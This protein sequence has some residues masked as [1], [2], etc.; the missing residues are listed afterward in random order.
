[1]ERLKK[2]LYLIL[3]N[4]LLFGLCACQNAPDHSVVTSKNDGSFDS[5]VV[6]SAA[7]SKHGDIL[8]Q[9]SETFYS[10]D[11]TVEFT[12]NLHET[13]AN[14]AMPVVEV[15]PHYLTSEEAQRVAS[16]LFGNVDFYE[17]EP[18][19]GA[20]EDVL[21]KQDCKEAIQ[22]WSPYTNQENLV[23]LVGQLQGNQELINSY[24]EMIQNEIAKYTMLL[25][26]IPSERTHMKAKWEFQPDWYY[27]YPEEVIKERGL[28]LSESNDQILVR[29]TYNNVPYLLNFSVRNKEDFKL[30]TIFVYPNTIYSPQAIDNRIYSAQ[31]CR[32][33]KPS[34]EQMD[35]MV[36]KTQSIL[37]QMNL[38]DWVVDQCYLQSD[39]DGNTTEYSV[40][41]TAVP[42]F[43]GIPA[44]RRNQLANLKSDD[45][46]ASNYYLTDAIFKF[47][48]NGDLVYLQ[49]SS[50][51]DI[52]KVVNENVETISI[53][54]LIE[55]AKE[56][57]ALSDY[58][59]YGLSSESRNLMMKEAQE[60][61]LCRINLCKIEYGMIRV[62]APGT[63]ESYYY[64]PGIILSG[65]IGYY[66][67]DS[68]T[69]YEF[70]DVSPL[71]ALNAVDGTFIEL[72]NNF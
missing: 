57:L 29:T 6:Q 56:H 28:D 17:S 55:T 25:E 53:E 34:E 39:N 14:E 45:T 36:E 69:A 43:N 11:G 54:K 38:G 26:E 60:D 23:K 30:N 18:I 2:A 15:N 68:G 52:K 58:Q 63:D 72:D 61:I 62:K 48:A 66:G 19:L 51:I 7:E 47:S 71:I 46:Y 50:P 67:K 9:F 42:T 64:V 65:S 24:L 40:V 32:T 27:T 8:V 20:L 5:S 21:T 3:I 70:S 41:I 13:F 10:T 35:S 31:L 22:R 16:V 44:I 33:V 12:L 59:A 4:V 1:M 37:D 49:L